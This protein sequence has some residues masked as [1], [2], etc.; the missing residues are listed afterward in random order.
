MCASGQLYAD[1]WCTIFQFCD[2][3]GKIRLART[4][5]TLLEYG[6]RPASWKDAPCIPLDVTIDQCYEPNYDIVRSRVSPLLQHAGLSLTCEYNTYYHK[7]CNWNTLPPVRELYFIS[8]INEGQWIHSSDIESVLTIPSF[9]HQVKVLRATEQDLSYFWDHLKP[10]TCIQ[11]LDLMSPSNLSIEST[12]PSYLKNIKVLTLVSS[13]IYSTKRFKETCDWL[14]QFRTQV[15]EL[16]LGF[17]HSWRFTSRLFQPGV[18]WPELTLLTLEIVRD[19]AYWASDREE[20]EEHAR[21]HQ[22]FNEFANL[23]SCAPELDRLALSNFL[24]GDVALL[25]SKLASR[26][27]LQAIRVEQV[28]A[29]F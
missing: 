18:I 26:S 21:S 28:D 17:T 29:V 9:A 3:V 5:T 2:H 24:L 15:Q 7:A 1:A 25:T 4:C 20:E 23:D 16:H 14:M 27:K 8:D 13:D 10:Y 11:E 6:S 19:S 22:S 12:F